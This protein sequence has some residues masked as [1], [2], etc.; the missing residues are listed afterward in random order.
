MQSKLTHACAIA[1]LAGTPLCA[2]AQAGEELAD[3]TLEQLSDVVV[4]SVARQEASLA[5][6]PASIFSIT[7]AAI[8]RAGATT[9][10][11]AL[12]LAP[13]LQVARASAGT[14]AIS[15]RGFSSTLANKLLV[16][17]DGRSVY[18][19]LFSGVFWDMQDVLLEDIE[20]I[21]VISG[22]GAT[23]WG[24]NAVNGV[25][26]IITRRASDTQGTLLKAG[27]GSDEQLGVARFGAPL[28]A[29]GHYRLY[30]KYGAH[31]DLED[32]FGEPVRSRWHR[33]QAGFRADFEAG[34][35]SAAVSGDAYAGSIGQSQAPDMRTAGANLVAALSRR[36]AG[37]SDLRLQFYLDHVRR[38]EPGVG[39]DRIGT[40]DLEFQHDVPLAGHV[41]SWGGGYRH[42]HDHVMDMQRLHFVPAATSLSWANLFVQDE[43][44]LRPG[45]RLV[46]GSKIERTNYTGLEWLPNVRLA[47]NFG[48]DRLAWVAASRALRAPSRID[49]DL[50]VPAR[51]APG[52]PLRYI[53]AGGPNFTSEKATVLEAGYRAQHGAALSYALTLF[54]SRYDDLRTLE[55]REGGPWEFRNMGAARTRGLEA[56]ARWQ[57]L[58]G[59]SLSGGG[60]LQDIDTW[61]EPGSRDASGGTRLAANDPSHYWRL[62]SAHDLGPRL[63][64]D[65]E[66][67]GVGR[68]PRPAA[69]SYHELDL[70]LGWQVAP[71][72]E[73]SVTGRNLLHRSHTEF[74]PA[75]TR[76][77]A[78]RA[79][80]FNVSARF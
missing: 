40:V 41:L 28:G 78:G 68:L 65:L 9:L 72:I 16:M 76:L 11:E 70:R 12:R 13:N 71:G 4:T 49:R 80:L 31:A 10:P 69:P 57:V 21:E 66:L 15:A 55:P 5:T 22:P 6:A 37:G 14:Y 24:T 42:A 52:E 43:L 32:D 25:I 33:R 79:V 67:R 19:P 8:R 7:G 39:K 47:Y 20:R 48:P 44:T 45:M 26:N 23:I 27:A 53:V 54:A 1:L 62:H 75:P 77:S 34:P 18:S 58:P 51:S 63:Q 73:A 30:A 38:D 59:W 36:F 29:H 3:F 61:I 64:L 46:L 35:F 17:I 2:T 74:G 50:H 56:W 60:V